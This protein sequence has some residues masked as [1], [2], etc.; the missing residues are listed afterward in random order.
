MFV[1]FV[2]TL[3]KRP[4]SKNFAQGD[5]FYI[6][7]D[8]CIA[9]GWPFIAPE[10]YFNRFAEVEASLWGTPMKDFVDRTCMR[11]IP[12]T[13]ELEAIK[14]YP[15]LQAYED[16]IIADYPSRKD[17]LNDLLTNENV[18]FEQII[19]ELFDKILCDFGEQPEG[20]LC[21]EILP[22]SLISVAQKRGVPV[23]FQLNGLL[24]RPLYKMRQ[25]PNASF[26]NCMSL[27]SD[28][29]FDS[30]QSRYE[31]FIKVKDALPIL[32]RKGIMRLFFD[33]QFMMDIHRIDDEPEYDIGVIHNSIPDPLHFFGQK[34]VP[35]EEM[36]LR[37]RE[38]YSKVLIR[39]R[40]GFLKYADK[41]AQDI[42]PSCYHFCCKCKRVV[43]FMTKGMFD[44]ML[45]GRITHEYGSFVFHLFCNN[46]LE[47]DSKGVAPLE[48]I[49][50]IIFA[51]WAPLPWL[52]DIVHLRLI[53]SGISE[54]ELYMRSFNYFTQDISKEDIEFY[55]MSDNRAYRLG[56]IL[57]FTSGHKPH[58]YAAYYCTGGLVSYIG[59]CT[60]SNGENTSFEFDLM[61]SVN[62]P[63]TI[64]AALYDVAMDWN[65]TNPAQTV[66]CL[67]NGVDCGSVTLTP[68]KKYFRFAIPAECF[69]DK[70]QVNFRYSYLHPN[71][72]FKH[73]VAFERMYISRAGQMFIEDAMSGDIA[74]LGYKLSELEAQNTEQK[75]LILGFEAQNVELLTQVSGHEAQKAELLTQVSGHEAQNAEQRTQI[76]MLEA[77]NAELVT[78]VSG[79]DAQNAELLTQVSGLE[80]KNG[81]KCTQITR[82]E[83]QNT[84]QSAHISGLIAQNTE[85]NSQLSVLIAHT[86]EQSAQISVLEKRNSEQEKHISELESQNDK[87]K[88]QICLLE[89]LNVEHK[90]YA[91]GLEAQIQ[92]IYGSRSWK[93][94]NGIIKAAVKI[95]PSKK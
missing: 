53:T 73:G 95:V 89:A 43:G 46:G 57:H 87:Q 48:F 24:R 40:P 66:S 38:K 22:K 15:I 27:K 81:E 9:Y 92:A 13:E 30:V 6:Y 50:F 93:L 25:H 78:K 23:I 45:A 12:T 41:N 60:W 85:Q 32:S 51:L 84:E 35:D 94:G 70:L 91:S 17:C 19:G 64:S 77:Q 75:T 11:K 31:S 65:S 58:E 5:I 56:D 90:A 76:Y 72:N 42:S 74:A 28:F 8:A 80:A 21:F 44:A 69:T 2:F 37:A 39:A 62:E 3:D 49:N 33:E 68:G 88:T 79:L 4:W 26:I 7:A 14:T 47:D 63:L 16:T 59:N 52:T 54:K 10:R 18:K 29:T 61:E 82:L 34:T 36:S 86:A 20:I 83:A 67:V 1:P 71:E 55:Y